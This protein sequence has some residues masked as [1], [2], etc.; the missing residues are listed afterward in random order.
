MVSCPFGT[1]VGVFFCLPL[2]VG[3]IS[4]SITHKYKIAVAIAYRYWY[5]PGGPCNP[6]W[7][8]YLCQ[9]RGPEAPTNPPIFPA[10][11]PADTRASRYI[12]LHWVT[13][14]CIENYY[15]D[16]LLVDVRTHTHR[17]DWHII[18]QY[19][20]AMHQSK[21]R[22]KK[23]PAGLAKRGQVGGIKLVSVSGSVHYF[24]NQT[25]ASNGNPC[26]QNYH[27]NISCYHHCHL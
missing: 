14:S 27:E 19:Q 5:P 3:F 8:K 9:C 12:F 10:I 16:R 26:Q 17:T 13:V 23:N 7:G 18:P 15:L 20:T 25:P 6:V 21:A 4:I 24:G 22:A 11:F 1:P 2:R